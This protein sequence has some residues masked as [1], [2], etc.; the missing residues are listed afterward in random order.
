ML[1]SMEK[2]VAEPE[3]HSPSPLVWLI[4]HANEAMAVVEGVEMMAL[5]DTRSKV[6]TLTE[7][8]CSEFWLSFFFHWGFVA[9]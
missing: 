2:L 3:H 9:S 8:F 1:V 5:V 6:S 7:G 4:G